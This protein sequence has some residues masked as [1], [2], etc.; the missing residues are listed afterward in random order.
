MALATG[1]T[2]TLAHFVTLSTTETSALRA[3]CRLRKCTV[4][5][6]LVAAVTLAEIEHQ[7][8]SALLLGEA[9]TKA[10]LEQFMDADMYP[11]INVH[12]SVCH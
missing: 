1:N 4:T 6:I 5:A 3:A 11:L 7:F 8:R 9:E 10:F 12:D 2:G